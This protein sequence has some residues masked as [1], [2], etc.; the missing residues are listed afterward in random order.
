MKLPTIVALK[1]IGFPTD[2]HTK[3]KKLADAGISLLSGINTPE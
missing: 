1:L 3:V 2:T